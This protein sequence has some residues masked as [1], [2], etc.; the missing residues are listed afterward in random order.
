MEV[1]PA[2]PVGD[3]VPDSR[4]M[5]E[6]IHLENFKSYA[7][8]KVLGPFHKCFSAVVGPNGSGKSNIF[9]A[10]LFVFG[11]RTSKMRLKKVD[12]LIHKSENH[13]NLTSASVSIFFQTIVDKEGDDFDVVP[14]TKLKVTRTAQLG[15]TSTY[16]INDKRSTWSEVRTLLKGKGI[17]LDNNRFL[18]LQGEVE[19]ISLMK[20]KAQTEHDV[21]LL[22]YLEDIIG[23][24]VYVKQIEEAEATLETVTHERT[25]KVN[26]VKA[27]ERELGGLE[28]AKM[29]AEDY[30]EKERDLR[31]QQA[32]LYQVLRL[33]AAGKANSVATQKKELEE[34]VADV[35]E[36][37]AEALKNLEETET[38]YKQ[39]ND[40]HEELN[41]GMST[42]KKSFAVFERK[43]VK[44]RSDAKHSRSKAK[45]LSNTVDRENKKKSEKEA[46]LNSAMEDEAHHTEALASL[47]KD[48]A[49]EEAKLEEIIGSLKDV[50]AG[51][52]CEMEE[53][54]KTLMPL[55]RA[56]DEEQGQLDLARSEL[57]MLEEGV[58][59]AAR[60]LGI[61]TEKLKSTTRDLKM[62]EKEIQT[63]HT[64]K[65]KAAAELAKVRQEVASL[66]KEETELAEKVSDR[67][68]KAA[69]ARQSMH[70]KS[71]G[72]AVLQS[73]M[74]AK[75]K[76]LIQ[77]I[78]GRLGDL[79]TIDGKYDVAAST[80]CGS[81]NYIVVDNTDAGQQCIQHLK[82]NNV[83]TAT[84]IMLSQLEHLQSRANAP[85]P[86]NIPRGAERLFDLVQP[87]TD[88][89]RT[90]FY[91]AMRETLVAKDMDEARA[92]A[93][94]KQG[95][96]ANGAKHR[97]V[98]MDGK[99]IDTSGTM[100]GGGRGV[101]R[102]AL[103]LTGKGGGSTASQ[104]VDE[105]VST[106][107]EV[108]TLE[109]RLAS[110][111]NRLRDVRKQLDTLNRGVNSL[112]KAV[113]AADMATNKHEMA[114]AALK[115]Q[116]TELAAEIPHL[117]KMAAAAADSNSEEAKRIKELAVTVKTLEGVVKEKAEA[118]APLEADIAEV[119]K[120]INNAGGVK[121]KVQKAKVEALQESMAAARNSITKAKVVVRS[122][123][124]SIATAEKNATA[125]EKEFLKESKLIEKLAAS[126]K[127]LEDEASRVMKSYEDMKNLVETKAEQLVELQKR[128]TNMKKG[129]ANL[130]TQ[131]VDLLNQ[132]E[133]VLAVV[134]EGEAAA[135]QWELKVA[136][137]KKKHEADEIVR[138]EGEAK[139]R[140]ELIQEGLVVED[141][142]EDKE[143]GSSAMANKSTTSVF[144]LAEEEIKAKDKSALRRDIG[145]LEEAIERM[146][147]NMGAI[148]EYRAKE[149]VRAQ[150]ASELDEVT[151]RRDEARTKHEALRKS[152]VDEFMAGFSI[153]TM[154]LKEMYQMITL[155]GD[156]ELELVDSLDP[157]S[158]GIV[159][160]VRPPKKS[161]KNISNLSG[162]EKTLS[163]LALVFA[164]HHYK[165]TPLY[166][167]DEIDAALDFRN[168]SIVANYIKERTKNAQ[169]III[170]LRNNMFE[171]ADRLVGIFKTDNVTKSVTINPSGFHIPQAIESAPPPS[172]QKSAGKGKRK[173]GG[174]GGGAR[175]L[176]PH[177]DNT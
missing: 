167:M 137:M 17:D 70:A 127:E 90:A 12:E 95:G 36:N 92:F 151:V 96:G 39:L 104:Q 99:L 72:N 130:R 163:S 81:L 40:D 147:P 126:L 59:S 89:F 34:E 106:Q 26:R 118:L 10:L 42:A 68:S 38:E 27:V 155:G 124:K 145:A 14:G 33:E 173:V 101:K 102:G 114:I 148:A 61:T 171:L 166:V 109:K 108:D 52:H 75:Q 82:R 58:D 2:V 87:R 105:V 88:Q 41:K 50:T 143:A 119:Q 120:K 60:Q 44:V 112:E 37:L 142:E 22:E 30:Q 76:G 172:T 47:T 53:L 110:A 71:S 113:S 19:M 80:A 136:A 94:G 146:N 29:E 31:S 78:H 117:K 21:G 45:K 100:S 43:D 176:A 144:D 97:V 158:E 98:T 3:A 91:F 157:F 11:Y 28:G 79:G 69:Q 116:E 65:T 164:L 35:R 177:S 156:A 15:G 25:E 140:A 85:T 32:L 56:S 131:E 169:F 48:S 135:K 168:V 125:A 149:A 46:A 5:I 73:I 4:L 6:K 9:D 23:T 170:S 132:L 54:Q 139:A 66:E 141:E 93:F 77:G 84:F 129:V 64:N 133:D 115:N 20:P 123:T 16:R 154:K 160:S 150:R 62:R 74:Q 13:P 7:G 18:I 51:L 152:R 1:S 161:W 111:V 159:F 55:R 122:A 162:G 83:G 107:Q 57:T 153:I 134:K 121:L 103:R 165:P 138:L 128:Y 63:A 174:G 86:S 67:R 24:N 8:L 175:P 49:V